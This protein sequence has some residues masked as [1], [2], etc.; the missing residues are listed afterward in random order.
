MKKII[1]VLIALLTVLAAV[2]I[3]LA[4]PLATSGYEDKKLNGSGETLD[5]LGVSL[6][7]REYR[8][9]S[10]GEKF[11]LLSS[12]EIYAVKAKAGNYMNKQT[13][14]EKA[15]EHF[16]YL[17]KFGVPS[18]YPQNASEDM[19]VIPVLITDKAGSGLSFFVWRVFAENGGSSSV[20][21]VDDETGCLL[22]LKYSEEENNSAN[23]DAN[24]QGTEG[25]SANADAL[26]TEGLNLHIPLD[27]FCGQIGWILLEI[28]E[29]YVTEDYAEYD[30]VI[31]E[32]GG[33]KTAILPL[34]GNMRSYMFNFDSLILKEIILPEKSN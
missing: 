2:G 1:R 23:V 5:S 18:A 11:E 19:D 14:G 33:E 13:A 30:I 21:I 7:V 8:S 29:I 4:L 31:G 32:D 3:G 28:Q 12:G 26:D 6:G 15:V 34:V 24:A 16:K 20:M 9:I 10:L 25:L 22:A 17:E 27:F